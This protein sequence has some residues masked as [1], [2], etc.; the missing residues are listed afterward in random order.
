MV[1]D[2]IQESS[3]VI[4]VLFEIDRLGAKAA[5]AAHKYSYILMTFVM[6]EVTV[7]NVASTALIYIDYI[8]SSAVNS[9]S[10][11]LAT[12]RN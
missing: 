1:Q 10:I 6:R 5:A 11:R 4:K 8:L 3:S 2:S 9:S 12:L 7:S